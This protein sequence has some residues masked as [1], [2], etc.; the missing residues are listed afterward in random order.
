MSAINATKNGGDPNAAAFNSSLKATPDK[1][2]S[3]GDLLDYNKPD[4]RDLL[5]KTFGDQGITGFLQLTGAT[6][7]AG[8]NDEVQYW[9]EGRLHKTLAVTNIG[10]A[11]AEADVT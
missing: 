8:T 3:L 7:S 5:I 9:E 11:N 10:S 4:N 2:V 6:R 1:Y